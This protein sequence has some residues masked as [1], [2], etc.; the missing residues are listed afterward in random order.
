[1][2]RRMRAGLA[3]WLLY[4]ALGDSVIEMRSLEKSSDIIQIRSASFPNTYKE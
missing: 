4:I 2:L 3:G 1:M